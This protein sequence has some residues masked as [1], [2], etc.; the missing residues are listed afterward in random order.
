MRL[1]PG[2]ASTREPE[3]RAPDEL[4]PSVTPARLGRYAIL[5]LLGQGGMGVVYAAFDDRLDRKVAIKV[6]RHHGGDGIAHVRLLREAQALARLS[7]PNVV[8]VHD[9]DEADGRIYIAMEFVT[10][11]TLRTWLGEPR[12]CPEIVDVFVQAGRG[13]AAAHAAGLVHRDFKPEN[14]LVGADGRVRVLDFGLVRFDAERQVV[15]E[16]LVETSPLVLASATRTAELDT[17][18]PRQW[19]V[20]IAC[21]VKPCVEPSRCSSARSPPSL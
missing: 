10:G 4:V 14:V 13:L 12:S 8:A 21:A 19:C 15:T 2:L 17:R 11:V 3:L 1:E 18:S 20:S 6:L 16:R 7:H 9:V 5:R